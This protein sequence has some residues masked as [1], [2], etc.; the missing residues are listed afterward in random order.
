MILVNCSDESLLNVDFQLFTSIQHEMIHAYLFASNLPSN[1]NKRFKQI[2]NDINDRIGANITIKH[3]FNQNAEVYFFRCNGICRSQPPDYGWIKTDTTRAPHPNWQGHHRKCDGRF[4]RVFDTHKAISNSPKRNN[5]ESSANDV[6]VDS[7]HN[8][9]TNHSKVEQSLPDPPH[10]PATEP[11]EL[12]RRN[13]LD[14]S[15]DIKKEISDEIGGEM[16]E[17]DLITDLDELP[18]DEMFA[19]YHEGQQ[20]LL[21]VQFLHVEPNSLDDMNFCIVCKHFVAHEQIYQHLFECTGLTAEQ[22]QYKLPF[23]RIPSA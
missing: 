18:T 8:T 13:A 7:T 21:S 14:I 15:L 4:Y 3:H 1:H 12:N 2:M 5:S 19:N 20:K 11:K 22:I 17:I 9:N 23:Y 10:L 6:N 16:C